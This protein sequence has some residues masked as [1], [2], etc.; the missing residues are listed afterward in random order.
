MAKPSKFN[1]TKECTAM[2]VRLGAQPHDNEF[3]GGYD[4]VLKTVA[5]P[6][7]CHAHDDWLAC[8]FRDVQSAV[9]RI[10]QGDL[11]QFSGKWNWMYNKPTRLD[12]VDL[13]ERLAGVADL[14]DNR[15]CRAYAKS[16]EQLTDQDH[17]PDVCL[18]YVYQDADNYK[19]ARD[20]FFRGAFRDPKNLNSL[21]LSLD[22]STGDAS[23]I[24]GELG[25]D[26][27]QDSFPGTQNQWDPYRD[28]P[29]HEVTSIIAVPFEEER[30]CD[31]RRFKEFVREVFA[32]VITAGWDESYRPDFYPA[33][34]QRFNQSQ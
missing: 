15:L 5:G 28:H 12:L 25:L 29:F 19:V 9:K 11:N 18:T 26:D 31:E 30:V 17:A 27:L 2:L 13:S 7:Q 3:G 10:H 21:V 6:L 20:V 16:L 23:L 4:L 33:M 22:M 24:P 14:S 32:H 1:F 8:K 34:K